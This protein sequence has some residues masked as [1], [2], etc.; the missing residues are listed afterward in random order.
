MLPELTLPASLMLL[1]GALQPH[2]TRPSFRTFCGLAAGLAGQGQRRTVAGMLL[3]A[4]LARCWPHDRAHYFF[5]RARWDLDQLG[6]AVTRLAG[7]CWCR[8]ARRS[9][10][11]SMTRCSAG[12]AAPCT[13]P[14]GNMT[15]RPRPRPRS[16]SGP[17][18]SPRASSCPCRS[19]PGRC[20]CR[21]WPGCTS[22]PGGPGPG[23][24]A[25]SSRAASSP[26]PPPWSPCWP[27]RSPAAPCTWSPMPAT[28]ARSSTAC[29]P[30]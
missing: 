5:V 26:R 30:A 1:L 15:G 20:V 18:S 29:R 19:A 14:G 2:F 3:G 7:C 21:C 8:R 22:R 27:P 10:W 6:L 16:A 23:A 25:A 9:P 12:P 28:T 13:V 4:G 24:G 17:A 11:R